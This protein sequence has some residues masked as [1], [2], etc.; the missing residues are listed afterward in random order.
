MMQVGGII[1]ADGEFPVKGPLLVFACG[2]DVW[3]TVLDNVLF[4]HPVLWNPLFL[5]GLLRLK[6]PQSSDVY[7]EKWDSF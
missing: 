2:V 5:M 3:Y 7:L 1:H 4:V 6:D